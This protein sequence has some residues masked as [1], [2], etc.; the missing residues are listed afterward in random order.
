MRNSLRI[1]GVL[2]VMLGGAVLVYWAQTYE[3]SRRLACVRVLT[4]TQFLT[5]GAT[6]GI[7]GK[8]AFFWSPSLRLSS[9]SGQGFVAPLPVDSTRW[10]VLQRYRPGQ[11]P[12]A[13]AL[14]MQVLTKV[15]QQR[16]LQ[17][18]VMLVSDQEMEAW[19]HALSRSLVLEVCR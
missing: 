13:V 3:Q 10:A 7:E 16:K 11:A 8:S 6:V 2:V 17:S 19:T 18:V 15:I 14:Q 9:E 4:T 12:L 5:Q 1:L